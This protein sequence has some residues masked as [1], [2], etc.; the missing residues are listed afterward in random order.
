MFGMTKRNVD[1]FL[2]KTEIKKRLVASLML[3]TN[4]FAF[5]IL[6]IV[7]RY[8]TSMFFITLASCSGVVFGITMVSMPSATLAEIWSRST[9]SGRV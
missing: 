8:F 9:S 7:I 2:S 3:A 5:V 1:Y 6:Q 4:L